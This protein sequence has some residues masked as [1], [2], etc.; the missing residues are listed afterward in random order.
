MISLYIGLRIL[1][2]QL[3][4]KLESNT[5]HEVVTVLE[6]NTEVATVNLGKTLMERVYQVILSSSLN[7]KKVYE[8]YRKSNFEP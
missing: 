7:G 1:C 8:F 4:H 5:D 3:N 6:S 2:H